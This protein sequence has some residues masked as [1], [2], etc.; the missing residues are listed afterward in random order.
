MRKFL[1]IMLAAVAFIFVGS[2]VQQAEA[3]DCY[4][5]TYKDGNDAYLMTETIHH[6]NTVGRAGIWYCT[7]KV[8]KG[9]NAF[10]IDYTFY[11]DSEGW[12]YENSQGFHAKVTYR[13]PIA[14]R[15]LDYM[16]PNN[17]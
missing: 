13:T 15:I 10:Y 5:G 17:R 7:V 8:V 9:N 1:I 6:D 16:V 11:A 4:V 2:Q 14:Q 3:A 12:K